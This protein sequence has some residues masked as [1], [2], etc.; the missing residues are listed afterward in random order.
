MDDDRRVAELLAVIPDIVITMSVDGRLLTCSAASQSLL[1]FAPEELIGHSLLD[2]PTLDDEGRTLAA[3]E[4]R[5]LLTEQRPGAVLLPLQHRDGRRRWFEVRSGIGHEPDGT[6]VVRAILRDTTER[7]DAE[8]RLRAIIDH[9]NDIIIVFDTRGILRFANQ[10]V[11]D[12][13]GY[14]PG[15]RIGLPVMDLVHPDDV[16]LALASLS[17]WQ[18]PGSHSSV[19]LRFRH[20]NGSHRFIEASGRNMSHVAAVGGIL[21]VGRDVT[22]RMRLQERLEAAERLDSIGR[23]AGGVAH[24]FNNLL[25]VVFAAA[26][27][28]RGAIGSAPTAAA[29]DSLALILDAA[30]RGRDLTAKLLTFARRQPTE[31]GSSVDVTASLWS[32]EALLRRLLGSGC[33]LHVEATRDSA[34]VPMAPAQF[35]QLLLNLAAN[36]RDAMPDG[37]M[38][39]VSLQ[40]EDGAVVRAAK[41][42]IDG[43]GPVVRLAFMDS[44]SGM[45]ADVA[46]RAFEPFYSTKEQGKGTGLG[47]ALVYGITRSVGGDVRIVSEPGHGTVVEL[48]LPTVDVGPARL[49]PD[50]VD[51]AAPEEVAG[52]SET[53]LVVEDNDDVRNLTTRTL[54]QVGYRVLEANGGAQALEMIASGPAVD[55]VVTDV[56]MPQMNGVA[57]AQELR[58]RHAAMPVLFITGY[59]PEHVLDRQ[60]LDARTALLTKPFKRDA[61]LSQVRHMLD[62]VAL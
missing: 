61:L 56:I 6:R 26:E 10:A 30:E 13:L 62:G 59:T 3:S 57:M 43:D 32:A 23:L 14:A 1:G 11:R 31:A 34:F 38:L 36:A 37:G 49:A 58:R 41:P 55:L 27:E 54:S 18:E 47:L 39:S 4:L 21:G 12:L 44:G 20:Q 28:L 35:E 52:G 50:R 46:A 42:Q 45:S 51:V 2:M 48:L 40:L 17:Q 24:D 29:A 7:L 5:T 15:E 53:V 8:Q 16:P 25:A 19:T 9:T 33:L 22:E 60:P